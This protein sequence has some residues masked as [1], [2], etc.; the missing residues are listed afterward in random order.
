MANMK[1]KNKFS[2]LFLKFFFNLVAIVSPNITLPL[3][4]R[5]ITP[6]DYEVLTVLSTTCM[7]SGN[8]FRVELNSALK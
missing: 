7:S 1:K 6:S 3:F 8:I 5:C 4:T 2:I